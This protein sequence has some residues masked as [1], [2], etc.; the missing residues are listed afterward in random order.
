M[1][2]LVF[3]CDKQLQEKFATI[4]SALQIISQLKDKKNRLTFDSDEIF[5]CGFFEMSHFLNIFYFWKTKLKY[6]S[7]KVVPL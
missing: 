5:I 3:L 4:L 6:W 2:K 1:R 7:R